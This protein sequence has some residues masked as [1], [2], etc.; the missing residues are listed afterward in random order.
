MDELKPQSFF[1]LNDQTWSD[2]FD[3]LDL[4]WEA[5]GRIKSYCL[6]RLN[7]NVAPLRAQGDFISRT[8]VL[9]DGRVITDGLDLTHDDATKGKFIVRCHGEILEG[10]AVVYAGAAILSDEV[11]LGPG[12]VVE[13]GAFIKGPALIGPNTEIRQ[14]AYVRGS[15][16]TGRACVV[17]HTTEMKNTFMLDGAKAGHFAYLGD[18]ILGR[19]VNLGAGTKLANLKILD[20]PV[21]VKIGDRTMDTGRRKFGA[22][23]GDNVQT[24]CNTVTSPGTIMAPGGLVSPNMTV[25]SGYHR[26]RA[27]IRPSKS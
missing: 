15:C 16:L 7:P 5:L 24:G 14:G 4:V 27:I 1:E 17:G 20:S 10:A 8:S 19:R 26:R 21:K 3:G 11:E 13:P 9:Y 18:S 6:E 12:V 23:L 25:P 22:I 2:L